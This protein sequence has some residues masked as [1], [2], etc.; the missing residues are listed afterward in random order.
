MSAHDTHAPTRAEVLAI[1]QRP[2]PPWVKTAATA[3]VAIGFL[4]FIGG[5]F[6]DAD[7]TW[8]AFHYDW[9]FF[10]TL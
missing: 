9:L 3:C 10:A 2:T 1:A 4:V 7:R 5:L 6:V 8:R